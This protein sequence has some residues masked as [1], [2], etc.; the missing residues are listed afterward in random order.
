MKDCRNIVFNIGDENRIVV[1]NITRDLLSS[2]IFAEPYR[3]ALEA[4]DSY[5]K[6]MPKESKERL[7][8]EQLC[9]NN[10]FAFIGDRG[11]RQDILYAIY[12]PI[13]GE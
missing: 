10:I 2:S 3:Y 1:E 11:S 7:E 13:A 6:S 8:E 4:L 9:R 5:F 12:S